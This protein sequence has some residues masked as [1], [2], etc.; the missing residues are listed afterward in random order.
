[1]SA[2]KLP[3]VVKN[4]AKNTSAPERADWQ[5]WSELRPKTPAWRVHNYP[6]IL[7]AAQRRS[8]GWNGLTLGVSLI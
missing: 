1:M 7:W 6:F 8:W 2:S 4:C 5:V 3:L